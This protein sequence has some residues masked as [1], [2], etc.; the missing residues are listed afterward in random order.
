MYSVGNNSYVPVNV[1]TPFNQLFVDSTVLNINSWRDHE[2]LVTLSIHLNEISEIPFCDVKIKLHQLC[3]KLME[4]VAS[5]KEV[6]LGACH[7]Y[8]DSEVDNPNKTT[9]RPELVL[10][11]TFYN[12]GICKNSNIILN[13]TK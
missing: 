2:V 4:K 11:T 7:F 6:R 12:L 9:N 1:N 8:I 13:I 5:M 10:D 3:N